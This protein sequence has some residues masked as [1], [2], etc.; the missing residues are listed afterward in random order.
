MPMGVVCLSKYFFIIEI[1]SWSL[2]SIEC[3]LM[4]GGCLSQGDN[5]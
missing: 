5:S 3:S 4:E 2:R 1:I